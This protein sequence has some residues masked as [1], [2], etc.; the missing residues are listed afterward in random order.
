M[1]LFPFLLL[2]PFTFFYPRHDAIR[3]YVP[4]YYY[5]KHSANSISLDVIKS[6]QEKTELLQAATT[7]PLDPSTLQDD[8]YGPSIFTYRAGEQNEQSAINVILWQNLGSSTSIFDDGLADTIA[9]D[10]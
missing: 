10:R 7:G 3:R 8:K 4:E 9:A 6:I 5:Y 1:L 2:R